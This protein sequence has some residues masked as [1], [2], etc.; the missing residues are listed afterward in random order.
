ME[1]IRKV[2]MLKKFKNA[3]LVI[4]SMT[5]IA[6]PALV[7]V[8]VSAQTDQIKAGLDCGSSFN[9]NNIGGNAVDCPVDATGTGQKLNHIL[10]LVINIFSLIVG[11]VAVIMIIIGGLRYITSGGES[12]NVSTAKNTIIYAIV[13]L[14]IVALAQ[15]IVHFVLAKVNSNT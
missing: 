13:G 7:P 9:V 10:T 14:V 2:T 8:A 15:F 1:A 11:V 4:A 12:S 6:A 3:L 5:A